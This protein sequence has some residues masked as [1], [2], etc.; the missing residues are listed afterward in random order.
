MVTERIFLPFQDPTV[1]CNELG[2][3]NSTKK[4][5]EVLEASRLVPAA[6]TALA[7]E[8]KEIKSPKSGPE[9]ALCEFAMKELDSILG[10]NATKVGGADGEWG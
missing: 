10:D 7:A 4:A 1:L 9:C 2:L 8:A 6:Q 5:V 3:C